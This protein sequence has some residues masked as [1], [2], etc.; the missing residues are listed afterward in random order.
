LDAAHDVRHY[1]YKYS[2]EKQN[3]DIA[4]KY[5]AIQIA[6]TLVTIANHPSKKLLPFNATDV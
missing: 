4:M 1:K 3:D 5:H 2:F 6:A